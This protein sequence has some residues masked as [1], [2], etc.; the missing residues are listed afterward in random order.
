[1]GA[2]RRNGES[3]VFSF[4]SFDV[5]GDGGDIWEAVGLVKELE[6]GR[7]EEVELFK[8]LLCFTDWKLF[9]KQYLL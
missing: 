4:K 5:R 3:R 8:V 7:N 6:S 9:S 1:M 2:E